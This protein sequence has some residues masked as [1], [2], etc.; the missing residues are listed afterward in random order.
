VDIIQIQRDVSLLRRS[1]DQE[2]IYSLH[3]AR[4]KREWKS[5]EDFI[6]C[7]NFQ[8][9]RKLDPSSSVVVAVEIGS[10]CAIVDGDSATTRSSQVQ[11]L[12]RQQQFIES[13]DNCQERPTSNVSLRMGGS[14]LVVA[15]NNVPSPPEGF[16]WQSVRQQQYLTTPSIAA[17]NAN[18]MEEGERDTKQ[19]EQRPPLL[20]R[21]IRRNDFPYYFEDG[22]EHWC[23][24]KLGLHHQADDNGD[25]EEE[26]GV[27]EKDIEWARQQLVMDE[28]LSLNGTTITNN[29]GKI[30]DMLHW[31]NP[32]HLKSVLGIDHAHILCL[33]K[34]G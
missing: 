32:P 23:L 5:V 13:D 26:A 27:T 4:L 17:N 18:S 14:L 7:R 2:K 22:I 10:S 15:P 11:E 1:I 12:E 16:V 34:D 6:L 33:R 8:F 21:V 25:L 20:Q 29:K 30:I 9:E 19:Q 28:G 3:C 31:V 24:W